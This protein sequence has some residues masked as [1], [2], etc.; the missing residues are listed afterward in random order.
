L[1]GK[2]VPCLLDT[3]C[4]QSVLPSRLL[5][6]AEL[7]TLDTREVPRL[8]A[9]NGAQIPILGLRNVYFSINGIKTSAQFAITN[10]ID[11]MIL[12]IEWLSDHNCAWNMG[13]GEMSIDGRI[14]QLR[15]RNASPESAEVRHVFCE[16]NVTIPAETQAILSVRAP[17]PHLRVKNDAWLMEPKEI[18]P[19]LLTG[20]TIVS[21]EISA[22]V[23]V[24]NVSDQPVTVKRGW[25]LGHAECLD[26]VKNDVS[27]ADSR[28][29]HCLDASCDRSNCAVD[30]CLKPGCRECAHSVATRPVEASLLR[31]TVNSQCGDAPA[32]IAVDDANVGHTFTA[33]DAGD[34]STNASTKR[35]SSRHGTVSVSKVAQ[36][37]GNDTVAVT[38]TSCTR[39]LAARGRGRIRRCDVAVKA[40]SKQSGVTADSTPFPVLSERRRRPAGSNRTP[41]PG[42][43]AL[44][45][46][47]GRMRDGRMRLARKPS[48]AAQI[49]SRR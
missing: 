21:G 20:R 8:K 23:P 17:L 3:G 6:N 44:K 37:S 24:I 38:D 25:F 46:T 27:D 36:R 5:K 22:Y 15:S 13:T 18:R 26:A 2:N 48:N 28:T 16:E 45:L 10:A 11:S 30:A 39:A 19:G 33:R 7:K 49:V 43:Y 29:C 9:A 12:G 41:S 32:C 14:V 34:K 31:Q 47:V 35:D 40:A 4:N 1:N 42:N